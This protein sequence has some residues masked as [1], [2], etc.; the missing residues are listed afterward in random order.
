[1]SEENSDIDELDDEGVDDEYKGPSDQDMLDSIIDS[2]ALIDISRHP[3]PRNFKK[4]TEERVVKM[5]EWIE[6]QLVKMKDAGKSDEEIDEARQEF[7]M[8]LEA[9]KAEYCFR[10]EILWKYHLAS[11]LMEVRDA[12]EKELWEV[13]YIPPRD[14]M[15]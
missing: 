14:K 11:V 12:V 15:H 2:S 9:N 3:V 7:E 5:R 1:M 6:D 10:D 8:I 4:D 13:E